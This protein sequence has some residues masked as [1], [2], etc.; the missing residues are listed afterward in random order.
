AMS[1]S[2]ALGIALKRNGQFR[3]LSGNLAITRAQTLR[4]LPQ[5]KIAALRFARRCQSACKFDP[6]LARSKAGWASLWS[7][8][9][10][11]LCPGQDWCER[12]GRRRRFPARV[13]QVEFCKAMLRVSGFYR[14][15]VLRLL[16]M[17]ASPSIRKQVH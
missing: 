7:T 11:S 2:V 15:G 8:I 12:E 5:L 13:A 6:C 16:T 9:L 17:T 14:R 4:C 3:L 1:S 10:D